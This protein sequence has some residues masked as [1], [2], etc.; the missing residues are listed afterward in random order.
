MASIY[1]NTT[2]PL[3][4][5]PTT[6]QDEYPVQHGSAAKNPIA[7][8]C[9]QEIPE[10][11]G[12]IDVNNQTTAGNEIPGFQQGHRNKTSIP[13]DKIGTPQEAQNNAPADSSPVPNYPQPNGYY[14][15]YPHHP[16]YLGQFPYMNYYQGATFP[17]FT[18][19]AQPT[20]FPPPPLQPGQIPGN[21]G[22][23]GS[24]PVTNEE[25]S[26]GYQIPFPVSQVPP[27]LGFQTQFPLRQTFSYLRNPKSS[28]TLS[29]VTNSLNYKKWV[30]EFSEILRKQ[31]LGDALP[32]R[33]KGY[34]KCLKDEEAEYITN[35]HIACVPSTSHPEWFKKRLENDL[36]L[37]DC[38]LEAVAIVSE[39]N[40]KPNLVH[41]ISTLS[42]RSR[43]S[44][45]DFAGRAIKLYERADRAKVSDLDVLLIRRVLQEL[46]S[47]CSAT[48][49]IFS[50]NEDKSFDALM[51]LLLSKQ[52]GLKDIKGTEQSNSK[53]QGK[54]WSNNSNERKQYNNRYASNNEKSKETVQHVSSKQA[55]ENLRLDPADSD[56]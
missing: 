9:N 56:Y 12:D 34:R 7:S 2:N 32:A 43:E 36:E 19:L 1:I 29:R 18:N 44:I 15:Y 41:E 31:G 45:E 5:A 20:A 21:N 27:G 24:F 49:L 53:H 4:Q 38:F 8:N 11:S 54:Q 47:E 13:A 50:T 37:I 33:R 23:Q 40:D 22:S 42:L 3:G 14:Y 17:P 52:W 55:S 26:Q 51:K 35:I 28:F 6:K 48:E 10:E 16:Q 46:P 25:A 30:G 39:E